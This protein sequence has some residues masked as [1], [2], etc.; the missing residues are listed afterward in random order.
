MKPSYDYVKY[1]VKED[2]VANGLALRKGDAIKIDIEKLYNNPFE[3][4]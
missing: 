1:T 2:L 3:W 4:K